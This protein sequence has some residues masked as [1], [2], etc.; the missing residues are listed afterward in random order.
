MPCA[1]REGWCRE[2]PKFYCGTATGGGEPF[3][4]QRCSNR[5]NKLRAQALLLAS[6]S[7]ASTAAESLTQLQLGLLLELAEPIHAGELQRVWT[8]ERP[9]WSRE[10]RKKIVRTPHA[11][12]AG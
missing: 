11:K 6:V 9:P 4:V 3:E 10:R 5:Y 7:L 12:K 1:R 2:Q 8:P